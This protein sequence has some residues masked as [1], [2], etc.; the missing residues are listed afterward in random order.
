MHTLANLSLCH[1]A[2]RGLHW[3]SCLI[4]TIVWIFL[5]MEFAKVS[6]MSRRCHSWTICVSTM[7]KALM[8]YKRKWTKE[9]WL[10]VQ[11]AD[12]CDSYWVGVI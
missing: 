4:E 7:R 5:Y 10:A 8:H 2:G 6:R 1:M 12:L 9:G 3:P 11:K